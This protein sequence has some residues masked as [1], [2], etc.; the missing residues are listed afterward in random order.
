MVVVCIG[1]QGRGPGRGWIDHYVTVALILCRGRLFSPAGAARALP[2][3]AAHSTF[4]S[5]TH[6]TLME[7]GRHHPLRRASLL[8]CL[9]G[10]ATDAG[11]AL[12][13]VGDGTASKDDERKKRRRDGSAGVETEPGMMPASAA[14][15]A[16]ATGAGSAAAA[17]LP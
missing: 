4:S 14:A 8:A 5:T 11:S 1:H 7:P 9:E 10:N 2:H 16:A 17:R 15:G 13:H 12:T 3:R 6:R